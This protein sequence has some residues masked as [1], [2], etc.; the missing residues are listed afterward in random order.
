MNV[1]V[2]GSG[3]R[4]HAIAH[5]L[6]QSELVTRVYAIPGNPAMSHVA[7]VHSEIAENDHLAIVDFAL[8]HDIKW[9]IIGPEQP[10]T[11]GLADA[12]RSSN[13]KV[14]GPNKEAAQIEGSKSFAKR[15]MAQYHIPTAEYREIDD[16]NEALAYIETCELPIVLKKDGLAAGKGVIIAETR[17]QAREAVETLYPEQQSKVVFEQFLVGEEFSLMTF[18]NGEYAVPFDTIAQDHK[19]A[20]DGDKGPNT[21][22]MGAYCPVPHMSARVLAEANEKIAQPIAQAMKAEGYDYFGLLYIGAILTDEGPK[23]IEFNARFGDPEA[24]VLLTRLESD[25]M[26]HIIELEEKAPIHMKWKDNAVVGVML[27]SKGYPA[28]Y[29]KGAKVTG[30]EN[31][32]GSYFV[33]GLKHNGRHFIN[34]G[35]RVILAIGEGET[36]E[37]AQKAAY[38]RVDKIESDALFYRKDIAHKALRDGL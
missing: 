38:A 17:E 6:N 22:G 21:G 1:L 32:P 15:L 14:F 18:V 20:Y 12:L 9:V 36:I 8:S 30:F 28:E 11:E 25:L 33:S 27:A 35:G 4:E 29:E 23:V 34:A 16:K 31:D 24:Q 19:R 10:L 3:G 37:A 2:I 5:K 13:I 7:E 26:A